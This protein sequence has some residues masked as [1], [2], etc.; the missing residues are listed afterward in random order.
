MRVDADEFAVLDEGSDHGPVIAAFVGAGE[1]G[2]VAIEGQRPD[3]ALDG[4]VVEIDT[5]VVDE[6]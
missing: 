5:A 1:Q 2:I 6:A 4:I 3:A